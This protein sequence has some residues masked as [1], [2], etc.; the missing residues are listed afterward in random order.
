MRQNTGEV[1]KKLHAMNRKVIKINIV[2]RRSED[3][4]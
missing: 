2:T 4:T 3:K 1:S